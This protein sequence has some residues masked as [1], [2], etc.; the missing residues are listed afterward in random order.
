MK[1]LFAFL[2]IIALLFAGFVATSGSASA[3]D[4]SC[5]F[6][7]TTNQFSSETLAPDTSGEY[8]EYRRYFCTKGAIDTHK[9]L[10]DTKA[11]YRRLKVVARDFA[12]GTD[13]VLFC[14]TGKNKAFM[15][16]LAYPYVESKQVPTF[17]LS[18]RWDDFTEKY[19]RT[20][21][22]CVVFY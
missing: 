18:S 10:A 9:T 7:G 6:F 15:L 22:N 4:S 3:S 20:H 2:L 12:D 13:V 11:E 14:K 16:Q 8:T 21:K 17:V 19:D 1:K 5:K